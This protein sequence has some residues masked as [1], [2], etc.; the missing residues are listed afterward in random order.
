[1]AVT[2]GSRMFILTALNDERPGLLSLVSLKVQGT[3]LTPGTVVAIQDSDGKP[4]ANYTV[5]AATENAELIQ[6][7]PWWVK[8]I[9]LSAVPAGTVSVTGTFE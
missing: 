4:V 2:L 9:K 5:L 1:M 3:G 8:G 7:A 6:G